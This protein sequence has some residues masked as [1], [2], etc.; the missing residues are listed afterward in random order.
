MHCVVVVIPV[1]IALVS[2]F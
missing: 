2:L 1:F